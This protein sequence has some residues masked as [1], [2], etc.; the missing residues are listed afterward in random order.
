MTV[1]VVACDAVAIACAWLGGAWLSFGRDGGTTHGA[2]DLLAPLL[3]GVVALLAVG[4]L[5]GSAAA[6]SYFPREAGAAWRVAVRCLT[7]A[8]ALVVVALIVIPLL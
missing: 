8:T 1:L 5:C 6:A 4:L 7:P 2:G 3:G